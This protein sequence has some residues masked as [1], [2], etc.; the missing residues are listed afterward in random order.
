LQKLNENYFDRNFKPGDK[1]TPLIEI[2]EETKDE[3]NNS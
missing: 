3:D 2:E 1:K